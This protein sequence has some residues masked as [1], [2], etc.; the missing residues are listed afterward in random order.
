MRRRFIQNTLT[1][2]LLMIGSSLGATENASRIVV[3]N[4]VEFIKALG[5]NR[6]VVIASGSHINLTDEIFS[7]GLEDKLN[8]KNIEL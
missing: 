1:A 3:H 6:T 8:I 5:S 7:E 4:G 2:L